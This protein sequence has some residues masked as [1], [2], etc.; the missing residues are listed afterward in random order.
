MR[1]SF[2]QPGINRNIYIYK[3]SNTVNCRFGCSTIVYVFTKGEYCK[4]DEMGG[5]IHKV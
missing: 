5:E 2:I 3:Y 4:T 1:A